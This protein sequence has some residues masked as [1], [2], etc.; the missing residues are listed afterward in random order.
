MIINGNYFNFVFIFLVNFENGS[1]SAFV[2]D[3]IYFGRC[4]N[5]TDNK[6]LT[7]RLIVNGQTYEGDLESNNSRKDNLIDNY[8]CVR[9]KKTN[10][11]S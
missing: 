9:N 7:G 8:I 2:K 3:D 10:K 4:K 6:Q 11:V 1:L 5:Q